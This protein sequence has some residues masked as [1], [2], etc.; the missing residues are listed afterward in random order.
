VFA[1]A[2]K[3]IVR[4]CPLR[5]SEIVVTNTRRDS[6]LIGTGFGYSGHYASTG[7]S[8]S[9]TI[10]DVKFILNG[11]LVLTLLNVD[12]PSGQKAHRSVTQ[13]FER[14]WNGFQGLDFC[15]AFTRTRSPFA[16]ISK[17]SSPKLYELIG[18]VETNKM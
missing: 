12:D 9:R 10:G 3:S 7:M 15:V 8:T 6:A 5:G 11:D 16:S 14:K 2:I 13:K 4:A 18:S 17:I 1:D